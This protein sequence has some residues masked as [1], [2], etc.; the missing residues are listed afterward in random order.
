MIIQDNL[1]NYCNTNKNYINSYKNTINFNN[2]RYVP[3]Q[4]NNT[5]NNYVINSNNNILSSEDMITSEAYLT[6]SNNMHGGLIKVKR[7][8]VFNSTYKMYII[9]DA[10]DKTLINSYYS[11]LNK[12]GIPRFDRTNIRP[13][14]TLMEILVNR[15]HPDYKYIVD[16]YGQINNTLRD[17]LAMKYKQ[18]SPQMYLKSRSGSYNIMGDFMAKVY[19]ATNSRYITDFRLVLYKYLEMLLGKGT[20]KVKNIDGKKYF[21]Y[22]YNGMELIA[23]P[24]YYHGKGNW[25]PHLSLIKLDKLRKSN[26]KLY[27]I[28]LKHGL[29]SLIYSLKGS[30]GSLTNVNLSYHFSILRV[31]IMIN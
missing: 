11:R 2:G 4:N 25:T 19:K 26:N 6:E 8:G 23:I 16:E 10:T 15:N 18:L 12:L 22:K 13:H 5:S 20:R 27:N 29:N 7:K 24:D 1:I 30:K 9:A 14:I 3:Y 31:S 21:Y 17:L 28:Y